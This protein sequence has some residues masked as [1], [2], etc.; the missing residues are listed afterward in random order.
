MIYRNNCVTKIHQWD[1]LSQHL[2]SW[3]GLSATAARTVQYCELY[4]VCVAT[5]WKEHRGRRTGQ[6]YC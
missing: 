1:F 3:E 2:G 4:R 6:E 5:K